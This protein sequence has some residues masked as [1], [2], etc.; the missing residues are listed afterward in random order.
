MLN[1]IAAVAV[2][3]ALGADVVK[4]AATLAGVKASPGRGA[5][6]RLKFGSGTV[7]LIIRG[8]A[9][10]A[11]YYDEPKAANLS[12]TNCTVAR[13]C[14]SGSRITSPPGSFR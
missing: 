9:D 1:S 4:A 5:R 3:E 11:V 8:S 7:E 13:T 6:R 14:S 10:Q 12:K 2:V